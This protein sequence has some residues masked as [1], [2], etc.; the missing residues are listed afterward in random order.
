MI[1]RKGGSRIEKVHVVSLYLYIIEKT[2]PHRK[3]S[4]DES[5]LIDYLILFKSECIDVLEN[6]LLVS[7]N[8]RNVHADRSF[9][10]ISTLYGRVIARYD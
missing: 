10:R 7:I 1:S 6:A 3:E 8:E 2:V 4:K 5:F 9:I